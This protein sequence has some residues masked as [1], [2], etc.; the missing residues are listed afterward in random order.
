MI[1]PGIT[2]A[3][4]SYTTFIGTGVAPPTP[5]PA[6]AFCGVKQYDYLQPLCQVEQY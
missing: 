1:I 2:A 3:A 6:G 4:T 5:T